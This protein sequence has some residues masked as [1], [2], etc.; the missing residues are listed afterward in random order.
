MKKTGKTGEPVQVCNMVSVVGT[1]CGQPVSVE[2]FPDEKSAM[3]RYKRLKAIHAETAAQAAGKEV[4]CT[5]STEPRSRVKTSRSGLPRCVFD[6]GFGITVVRG[7]AYAVPPA[8][9]G[10]LA[11]NRDG[12]LEVTCFSKQWMAQ[13]VFDEV[14]G[15]YNPAEIESTDSGDDYRDFSSDEVSV[16]VGIAPLVEKEDQCRIR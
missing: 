5:E 13:S 4:E 7:P 6:G 3:R 2:S 10:F 8:E 15:S 1:Y 16:A 11:V 12:R 9:L 14:K